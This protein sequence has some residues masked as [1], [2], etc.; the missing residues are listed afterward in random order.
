MGPHLQESDGDGRG[1]RRL[2]HHAV[3]LEFDVPSYRTEDAKKRGASK[4]VPKL[5]DNYSKPD[6][7]YP[8]AAQSKEQA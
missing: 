1:H 5:N 8:T 2:V 6:D 4:S 3:I 7:N